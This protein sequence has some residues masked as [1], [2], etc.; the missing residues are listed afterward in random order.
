[1]S[2][3]RWDQRAAGCIRSVDCNAELISR[4]V[5]FALCCG[6]ACC[7]CKLS[8]NFAADEAGVF[9]LEG[10]TPTRFID[11]TFTGNRAGKDG[12]AMVLHSLFACQVYLL[13][14][15]SLFLLRWKHG[16]LRL[17]CWSHVI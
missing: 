12:G 13:N 11:S 1:M 6:A 2:I 14:R 5:A 3:R 8:E 17:D 15:A 16:H 4:I 7:V 10:P 9:W